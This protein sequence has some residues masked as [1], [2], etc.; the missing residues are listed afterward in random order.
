MASVK[1]F[2]VEWSIC[3]IRNTTWEWRVRKMSFLSGDKT[4]RIQDID[5]GRATHTETKSG[6]EGR[7]QICLITHQTIA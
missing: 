5:G 7:R 2:L 1:R 6:H 3:T 4:V